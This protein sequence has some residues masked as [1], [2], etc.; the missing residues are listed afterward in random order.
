MLKNFETFVDAKIVERGY[1]YF[2]DDSIPKVEKVGEGEFN[3][4]VFGT[5]KYDV[6]VKIVDEII[7]EHNCSCPYDW[8]DICKHEVAVFYKLRNR[9]F[10]NI[11]DKIKLLLDNLHDDALRRFVSSLIKEDRKFRQ[12]FLREFDEDFE[13]DEEEDYR[14]DEYNY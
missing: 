11:G 14:F 12:N 8:G 4:V 13:E 7:T 10:I 5:F 9:N 2:K 6:Y 3:A 1:G